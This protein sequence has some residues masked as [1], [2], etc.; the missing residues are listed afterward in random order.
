MTAPVGL[1]LTDHGQLCLPPAVYASLQVH[2]LIST[3]ATLSDELEGSLQG[4]AG[5]AL[6]A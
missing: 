3:Q 2:H 5:L 1:A 6:A 4:A